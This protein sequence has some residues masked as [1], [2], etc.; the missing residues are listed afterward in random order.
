[1][2]IYLIFLLV[3]FTLLLNASCLAQE[4]YPHQ[5]IKPYISCFY[6]EYPKEISLPDSLSL[7]KNNL[8]VDFQ[9]F[10]YYDSSGKVVE[11]CPSLLYLKENNFSEKII[12]KYFWAYPKDSSVN[13][14]NEQAKKFVDWAKK[15][16]P[17]VIKFIH[18]PTNIIC[19]QKYTN[20]NRY[21][22][23]IVLK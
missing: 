11:I 2:K 8:F 18:Y 23:E 9:F 1:M 13:V 14:S 19:T 15:E 6:S 12:G 16:L 20:R 4:N 3:T 7:K 21:S 10:C 5:K 22:L 17:L